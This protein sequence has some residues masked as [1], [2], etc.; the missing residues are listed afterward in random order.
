MTNNVNHLM[1]IHFLRHTICRFCRLSLTYS[2][3]DNQLITSF[4]FCEKL[5]FVA[6][7]GLRALESEA[8]PLE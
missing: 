4:G 2:L 8:D 7:I 1:T 5:H 6:I 3:S